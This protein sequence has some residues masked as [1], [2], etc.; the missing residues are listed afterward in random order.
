VDAERVSKYIILK[1]VTCIMEKSI[2][3]VD[4]Y[5]CVESVIEIYMELR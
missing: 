3:Y 4:W 2:Y 1:K 5:A